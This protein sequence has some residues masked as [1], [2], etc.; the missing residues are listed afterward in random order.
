MHREAGLFIRNSSR[1]WTNARVISLV[2]AIAQVKIYVHTYSIYI[3]IYIYIHTHTHN[4]VDFGSSIKNNLAM[5]LVHD[6]KQPHNAKS[7]MKQYSP[8]RNHLGVNEN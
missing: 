1:E 2:Q 7:F 6:K 5:A 8:V 3:Y 4:H